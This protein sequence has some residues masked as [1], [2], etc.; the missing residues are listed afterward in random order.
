MVVGFNGVGCYHLL[1]DIMCART[2][3]TSIH[4]TLTHLEKIG[5]KC[6]PD[7]PQ[8]LFPGYVGTF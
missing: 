8:S 4:F 6:A 5:D 7:S 3:D 1:V 2:G